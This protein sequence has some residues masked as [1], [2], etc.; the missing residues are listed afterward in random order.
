MKKANE[1]NFK[2][3]STAL[4]LWE[5]C[6]E[7]SVPFNLIMKLR[8]SRNRYF[9]HNFDLSVNQTKLKNIFCVLNTLFHTQAVSDYVDRNGCLHEL[10]YIETKKH[11]ETILL[12]KVGELDSKADASL[13]CHSNVQENIQ[14]LLPKVETLTTKADATLSNQSNLQEELGSLLPKVDTL[15]TKTDVGICRQSNMQEEI[16]TILPKVVTLD[17]KT[18]VS[19]ACQSNLQE[20]MET[21]LPKVD[22]LDTKADISLSRLESISDRTFI[23]DL[24]LLS[25]MPTIPIKIKQAIERWP[26]GCSIIFFYVVIAIINWTCPVSVAM[27]LRPDPEGKHIKSFA[28]FYCCFS[29]CFTI[30]VR[31]QL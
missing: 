12:Q 21:L 23:L 30:L 26:I 15:G 5:H 24:G 1:I 6:R 8:K 2:D 7:Y 10:D 3:L 19:I 27:C 13:S 22:T 4:S 18:D 9:A 14:A 16:K 28:L 31:N 29:L 11:Y 25:L 17:S 20:E